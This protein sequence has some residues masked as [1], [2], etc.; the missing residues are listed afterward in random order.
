ML[1][2]CYEKRIST[3]QNKTPKSYTTYQHT[4]II[5]LFYLN[6]KKEKMITI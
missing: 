2:K 6:F 5:I 1:I 3:L 4:I